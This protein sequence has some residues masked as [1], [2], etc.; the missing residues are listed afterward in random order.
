MLD[1]G[2]TG[3]RFQDLS[4]LRHRARVEVFAG[5]D[6]LARHLRDNRGPSG[7]V[8]S[9]GAIPFRRLTLG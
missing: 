6:H 7:H 2:E 5:N 8:G 1:D 3:R 4:G 9:A